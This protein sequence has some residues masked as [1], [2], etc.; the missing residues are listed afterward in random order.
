MA[1]SAHCVPLTLPYPLTT[2]CSTTSPRPVVQHVYLQSGVY[3][4]PRINKLFRG[5]FLY[6]ETLPRTAAQFS[7]Y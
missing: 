2:A 4:F 6:Q 1:V 3:I 7:K 5:L